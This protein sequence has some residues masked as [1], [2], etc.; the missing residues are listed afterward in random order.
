MQNILRKYLTKVGTYP[1]CFGCY[2]TLR[3]IT[4]S[5]FIC[6]LIKDAISKR[7]YIFTA[8]DF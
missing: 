5:F 4:A 1:K 6:G 8:S 2:R 7:S 3:K